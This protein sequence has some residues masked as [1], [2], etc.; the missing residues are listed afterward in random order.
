MEFQLS[1]TEVD[2]EDCQLNNFS[3]RKMSSPFLGRHKR[4]EFHQWA[5]FDGNS[6]EFSELLTLF[7]TLMRWMPII[8]SDS[9]YFIAFSQQK[10][11][12]PPK[13][14]NWFFLLQRWHSCE[15]DCSVVSDT[16]SRRSDFTDGAEPF[17]AWVRAVEREKYVTAS[18]ICQT[19]CN[20][21]SV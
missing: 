11:V 14:L 2:D 4:R 16:W 21:C 13:C 1:V 18:F 6:K 5:E 9:L 12:S 19:S 20:V 3:G 17:R 15:F 10:I 7:N 8:P